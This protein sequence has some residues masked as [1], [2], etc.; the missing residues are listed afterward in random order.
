M[1]FLV[2]RLLV[3]SLGGLLEFGVYR[4]LLSWIPLFRI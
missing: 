3:D 1:V 2:V 4:I